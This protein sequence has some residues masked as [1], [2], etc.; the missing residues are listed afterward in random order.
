LFE[1]SRSD[2]W[3]DAPPNANDP[4]PV[5]VVS[6]AQTTAC[7]VRHGRLQRFS[8]ETLIRFITKLKWRV[9]VRV[10]E[11]PFPRAPKRGEVVHFR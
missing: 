6:R 4:M 8:V 9:E 10:V 2:S 7:R 5:E 1:F 3:R 11:P